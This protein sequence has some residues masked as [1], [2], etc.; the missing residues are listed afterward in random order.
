MRR[1]SGQALAEWVALLGAACAIAL[2]IA[3][4]GRALTREA[5]AVDAALQGAAGPAPA[6][7]APSPPSLAALPLAAIDGTPVVAI[8]RRLAAS[9]IVE[10]PPGSN[11]GPA[12]DAFTGGRAEPWCADFVSWVLRAAGRPLTDGAGGWRLAWTGAVRDW[13]AARGRFRER[14]VADPQPGDVVW[15]EH[16]HVGIVVAV[17]GATLETV[18]GNADDA[19]RSRTYPHWRSDADIGGFGRLPAG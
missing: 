15:F 3:L 9:A 2:A 12:I 16:G 8:A 6:V 14:L 13:F 1:R 5:A 11:R 7:R 19:V 10:R 17:R 18:E 4:G